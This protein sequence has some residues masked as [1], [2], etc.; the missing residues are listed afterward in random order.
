MK[1]I[2]PFRPSLTCEG[3]PSWFHP[4]GKRMEVKAYDS[5]EKTLVMHSRAVEIDITPKF[6]SSNST[7]QNGW[8]IKY[9]ILH[10][11]SMG[12]VARNEGTF[13]F[14]EEDIKSAFGLSD[15]C[16][17]HTGQVIID[18]AG[19]DVAYQGKYIRYSDYLNIPGPGTSFDGDPNL[20]IHLSYT[21]KQAVKILL[22]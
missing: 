20:S 14:S 12:V 2:K 16:E 8:V 22:G 18:H 4:K 13:W 1:N 21:I 17:A 3:R 11:G 19:G 10:D 6:G 5:N 7:K 15:D 9:Q